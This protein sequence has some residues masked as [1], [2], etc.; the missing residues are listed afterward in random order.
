MYDTVRFA[1]LEIKNP[2]IAASGCF[3][4][5]WEFPALSEK[6]GAVVAKTITVKPREGNSPP[7]IFEVPGGV[8][9]RVGLQNCGLKNFAEKHLPRLK[10]IGTTVIVSIFGE[11]F[12]QWAELIGTLEKEVAALELNLSCP[13]LNKQILTKNPEKCG[14]IVEK[15]R[16]LTDKPL[17]AKIN[18]VDSPAAVSSLLSDRGIDAIVCSNTI[19]ARVELNGRIYKGGLSGRLIKNFV[20]K[21][22]REIRKKS[23]VPIA[24]CGGIRGLKDVDDYRKAGADVFVL[25]SVLLRQPDI[26]PLEKNIDSEGDIV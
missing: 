14:N 20:L 16:K 24:A 7:R 6:F 23:D 10:K 19:P 18:A 11:N 15:L 26:L 21:A 8:I 25:G 5:G 12:R 2:F 1:G 4:Y 17:I 13:N 3:G 9:N 22:I